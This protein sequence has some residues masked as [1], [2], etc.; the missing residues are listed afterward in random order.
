MLS[1]LRRHG[2]THKQHIKQHVTHKHIHT[3]NAQKPNKHHKYNTQPTHNQHTTSQPA[4]QPTHTTTNT[5]TTISDFFCRDWS[6]CCVGSVD[7]F[8]L[9]QWKVLVCN[10]CLDTSTTLTSSDPDE[11]D[12]HNIWNPM[13]GLVCHA[14][15]GV[16]I[17][18]RHTHR[19]PHFLMHSFCTDLFLLVVRV[20]SRTLTSMHLHG[21]SHEAHCLRFTQKHSHLIL[22]AQCRTPCR[23]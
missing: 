7:S 11:F 23:T 4:N 5:H 13:L 20:Y 9:S 15:V 12:E 10:G 2:Q 3:T 16:F 1:T 22:V 21:S 6:S 19:A 8:S 17:V 14:N 18:D